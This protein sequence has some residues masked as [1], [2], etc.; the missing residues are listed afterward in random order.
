MILAIMVVQPHDPGTDS[1]VEK[2]GVDGR[3][4]QDA[5]S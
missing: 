4:D 5:I 3:A 1:T 2:L